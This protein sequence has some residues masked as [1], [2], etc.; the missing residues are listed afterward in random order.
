MYY[1]VVMSGIYVHIPFCIKKCSYCD[2]Y[3]VP[4]SRELAEK[5]VESLIG[6]IEIFSRHAAP[7]TC[8][9]LNT[10]Y[11][12]GGTPSCLTP[13]L[14]SRIT[15][16]IGK[17][18]DLSALKEFTV[19]VNPGTL[20]AEKLSAYEDGGV[21]RISVGAQSF[22]DK[23]L[24]KLGRIHRKEDV[25]R[26][27]GRVRDAGFYNVNIDLIFGLPLQREKEVVHD[28]TEAITLSPTHISVY[29]L[30]IEEGTPLYEEVRCGLETPSDDTY[31]Q[32]YRTLCGLMEHMGYHHYEISN[33]ARKD[34]ECAHNIGYW[35]GEEYI[36]FGAS[37]SGHLKAGRPR[38]GIR[39]TNHGTIG[40]Y[41]R[42]IE[43]GQLPRAESIENDAATAWK[44]RLIMGLR[45][46]DGICMASIEGELGEPPRSIKR[47]IHHLLETKMLQK[48][49]D[50]LRIPHDF[51]FVSN[52]ILS[53]LV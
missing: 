28:V 52:E 13:G 39:Y 26:T 9:G 35:T 33:F 20:S 11:I 36:A 30:S 47:S 3:S 32:C 1:D 23:Y 51:I 27:V 50:V 45:L 44:E 37:A 19:E 46:T 42:A 34:F 21:N 8:G 10:L 6:E 15:E 18:F 53:R 2:F 24:K 40:E 49:G 12:G 22:N 4:Y 14:F 25:Y 17:R 29:A 48:D 38:G 16:T 31:A 43:R 7:G 5:Y 41:I